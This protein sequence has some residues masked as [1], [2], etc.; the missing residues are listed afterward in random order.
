MGLYMYRLSDRL[1]T[2]FEQSTRLDDFVVWVDHLIV[3]PLH[4]ME[5]FGRHAS[6][7]G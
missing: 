5:D 1:G 4:G 3:F 6:F 2:R 7:N